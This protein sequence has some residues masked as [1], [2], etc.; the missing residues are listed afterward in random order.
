MSLVA[1]ENL[2]VTIMAGG[3][4]S[5]FWPA[6]HP[7]EPKQFLSIPPLSDDQT[8]IQHTVKRVLEKL[9]AE[10]IHIVGMIDHLALLSA[11]LPMLP[12]E[13]LILEPIGRNTAA[14]IAVGANHIRQLSKGEPAVQ[15]VL[16]ADHYIPDTHEFWQATDAGLHLLDSEPRLLVYG[17]K[18]RRPE[19]GYGYIESGSQLAMFSDIAVHQVS[20]FHEKPDLLKANKYLEAGTFYWNAGIFLWPVEKLLAEL[21][22]ALPKTHEQCTSIELDN[23]KGKPTL[24]READYQ[25]LDSISI[26]YGLLEKAEG[27][28]M[29]KTPMSWSD[30]GSWDAIF[31]IMKD[32]KDNVLLSGEVLMDK[33]KNCLFSCPNL[34]VIAYGLEDIIVAFHDGKLLLSKRGVASEIRQLVEIRRQRDEGGK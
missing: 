30:L 17:I 20:A 3:S 19:T 6:S 25:S 32:N 29:I 14:S 26:D 2:W 10:R 34:Q 1:K 23:T 4:G 18:P 12:V 11:Q 22:K 5:R 15:L 24:I 16:P 9:P 8:L 21:S 27:L 13:N 33:S 31:E 7:Q 28:A